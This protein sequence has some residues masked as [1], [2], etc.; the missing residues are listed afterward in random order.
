MVGWSAEWEVLIVVDNLSFPVV[1][2][3]VCIGQGD[4]FAGVRRALVMAISGS[5][6][7]ETIVNGALVHVTL[8][9]VFIHDVLIVYEWIA[10]TCEPDLK[11]DCVCSHQS[12]LLS[13][14][15]P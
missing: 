1:L 12:N 15:E 14:Y 10:G 9:S 7:P 11:E 6:G 3:I 8:G 5:Y 4:C 2:V 13:I